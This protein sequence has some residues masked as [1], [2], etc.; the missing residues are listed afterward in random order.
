MLDAAGLRWTRGV[1][2]VAANGDWLAWAVSAKALNTDK[3]YDLRK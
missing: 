2:L 3:K 1:R